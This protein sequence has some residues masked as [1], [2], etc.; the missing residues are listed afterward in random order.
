MTLR[1][2][3]GTFLLLGLSGFSAPQAQASENQTED[4]NALLYLAARYEASVES[5]ERLVKR[6]R[7]IDRADES[8]VDRLDDAAGRLTTAAKNPRYLNQLRHRLSDVLKRH[9]EVEERIFGKYTLHHDLLHCW[10]VTDYQLALLFEEY[11]LEVENPNHT[12]S[13]QPLRSS[14]SRR[15]AYL[16]FD[17]APPRLPDFE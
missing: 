3:L 16:Q 9:A 1:G 10:R 4:S 7:G 12:Q 5:F 15:Q 13:V 11:V 14:N 8:L 17:V 2:W 6:V